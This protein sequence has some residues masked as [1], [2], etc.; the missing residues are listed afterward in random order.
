MTMYWS[1]DFGQN[2]TTRTGLSTQKDF[3]NMGS[4]RKRIYRF[5]E[6]SGNEW[7]LSGIEMEY[8]EGNK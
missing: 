1:D 8:T 2:W 3:T 4:F 5:V 6:N 7:A